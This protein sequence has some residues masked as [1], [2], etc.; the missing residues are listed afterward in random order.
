MSLMAQGH[1]NAAIAG[2]MFVSEKTVSKHSYQAGGRDSA[3]CRSPPR[4]GCCSAFAAAVRSPGCG[5]G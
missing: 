4:H 5:L 2:R 1:F 3:A